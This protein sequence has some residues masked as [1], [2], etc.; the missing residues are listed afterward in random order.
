MRCIICHN[1]YDGFKILTMHTK[2]RKGLIACHKT[3]GITTMKKRVEVDHFA[4]VKKLAND[5]N[6]I[7]L[8]KGLSD[9][10]AIK[11]RCM[12]FHL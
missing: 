1:D 12:F 2:F 9:Q 10:E 8:A 4:L 5:P 11:K 7:A 6:C 3:N